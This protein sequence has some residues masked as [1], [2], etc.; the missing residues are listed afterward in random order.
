MK[1]KQIITSSLETENK[2]LKKQIVNLEKEIALLKSSKPKTST[3]SN[4]YSNILDN[5]PLA[6][7]GLDM[8][9]NMQIANSYFIKLFDFNTE[10]LSSKININKFEPLKKTV[11]I[12][13]INK[14]LDNQ[15]QFDYEIKIGEIDNNDSRFRSRGITIQ[16][17]EGDVLSYML[18]IG[19]ITKRKIAENNL[20]EAKEKAEESSQLKTAFLS[21]LSHEIR[22]PLN[23]ILGFLELLLINETSEEEREEYSTIIRGSSDVLLKRIDD[24]IDIS[25]IETGQMMINKQEV[26]AIDVLADIY[27]DC[28]SFKQKHNKDNIS[29]VL[30]KNHDYTKVTISTDPVK[31]RQII[32]NFVDN[33]FI[34]TSKG[35]VEIGLTIEDKNG[36]CFYV[37]DT[38][39]GIEKIHH[40]TIFEHFRQVDNTP[41]R[42]IGG[43][44]LGLAISRGLSHLLN[45][46]ISMQSKS[47]VGSVFY[48]NLP[49]SIVSLETKP[50]NTSSSDVNYNWSNTTILV[51]EYEEIDYNLIK[52]MLRKTNVKLIRAKTG[53]EAVKLFQEKIPDLILINYNLPV[54]NGVEFAKIIRSKKSLHPIIAQTDFINPGDNDIAKDAG[55]DKLISK[56]LHKNGLLNT[57]NDLIINSWF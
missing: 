9:G 24:I 41:T 32:F 39:V 6:I 14:L 16:S 26:N 36:I 7:L 3:F 47:G 55:I 30:N 29:L 45:G 43:S 21:N 15:V 48:L 53:D 56:P 40:E 13:K 52:I 28:G 8:E 18:I 49:E 22:T 44:G 46:N 31:L 25:K 54:I 50:A 4:L 51:A 38:G 27:N 20:I 37:K 17:L 42:K 34:F 19:D 5:I 2:L 11:L 23:H 57:I 1:K 33:A 10:Q 35:K 12:E